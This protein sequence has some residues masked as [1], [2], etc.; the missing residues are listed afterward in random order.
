MMP[1][2]KTWEASKIQESAT[3]HLADLPILNQHTDP[4]T[5]VEMIIVDEALA[6]SDKV[7][8]IAVN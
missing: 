4:Y 1:S 3:R 8:N 7:L 2:K 5:V 6:I